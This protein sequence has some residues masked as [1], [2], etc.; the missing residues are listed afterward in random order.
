MSRVFR[1]GELGHLASTELHA[2]SETREILSL[3]PQKPSP[4]LPKHRS[5]SLITA[6]QIYTQTVSGQ[7]CQPSPLRGTAAL[8]QAL[9]DEDGGVEAAEPGQQRPAGPGDGQGAPLHVCGRRGALGLRAGGRRLEPLGRRPLSVLSH[10][11]SRYRPGPARPTEALPKLWDHAAQAPWRSDDVKRDSAR[12]TLG[13]VV[14]PPPPFSALPAPGAP[15]ESR[16][17][18]GAQRAAKCS[19]GG[20]RAG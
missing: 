10:R 19:R 11:P 3:S 12:S 14:P 16:K 13:V 18:R 8:L 4:R 5:H 2:D 7:L 1:R 17:N 6:L 20:Q 15:R 9:T